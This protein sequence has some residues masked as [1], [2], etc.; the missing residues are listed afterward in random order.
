MSALDALADMT[1]FVEIV[2][3]GSLSAAG[4]ALNL[5]K[6]SV[7]RRLLLM[8]ARLGAP[9]LHRSTRIDGGFAGRVG[10]RTRHAFTPDAGGEDEARP[11]LLAGVQHHGHAEDA[12]GFLLIAALTARA[13]VEAHGQS[14][15]VMVSITLDAGTVNRA[16]SKVGARRKGRTLL[17]TPQRSVGM[18]S[19]LVSVTRLPFRSWEEATA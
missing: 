16:S 4:R 5:P 7:S 8:E 10:P 3:G 14:P 17:D 2:E 1:L 6:A 18:P 9:L 11:R 15:S 19:R 12:S 13:P